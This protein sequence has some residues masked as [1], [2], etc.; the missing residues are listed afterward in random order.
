MSD[1]AKTPYEG[2]ERRRHRVYVT[3]NTEYHF[4]D[5]RC[6]AV[7]DRTTG[8]WLVSHVALSRP[9]S[10]S[11]RFNIDGDAY[12]TLEAPGIGDALFFATDGPD[13]VTSSLTAVDRPP[14]HV[15]GQY[16]I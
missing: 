10:G 5:G 15:V 11:V 1:T 9:I 7:R 3:R 16:P 4:K 6:V 12:P 8:Q 14:K 2:Q 13:V